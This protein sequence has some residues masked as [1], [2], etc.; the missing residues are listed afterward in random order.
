MTELILLV[1][2]IVFAGMSVA[3]IRRKLL[4]RPLLNKMRKNLPPISQTEREALEAGNTWWDAE[5]FSG[6]PD[7]SKLKEL[8]GSALSA[9]EQAYIDGPVETL[10]AMLNDWQIT[11]QRR[12]LPPEVWDYIKQ[13]QFCGII[14]PKKYG[15]LAFSDFAHSQIVMKIASRSTTAAVTVM[16]PNSLGLNSK[17]TTICRAWRQVRK[18]RRLL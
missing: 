16:V 15:G 11:H 4:T 5:L 12:D 2:C 1:L 13:Q 17:K 6:K 10:C 18:F 3:P 14:I 9:A 7:W 8:P